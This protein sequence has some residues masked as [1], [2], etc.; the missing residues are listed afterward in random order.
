MPN[1]GL[2]QAET[3][4]E[5]TTSDKSQPKRARDRW[6][7]AVTLSLAGTVLQ[8]APKAFKRSL[9]PLASSSSCFPHCPGLSGNLPLFDL[10]HHL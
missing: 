10:N 8:H 1:E 7:K 6:V 3:I 5:L 4:P 9:A 2:E